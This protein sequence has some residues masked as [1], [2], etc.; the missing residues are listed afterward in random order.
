[1]KQLGNRTPAMEVESPSR[2]HRD[3]RV[4]RSRH[5]LP[6]LHGPDVIGSLSGGGAVGDQ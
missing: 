5:E 3:R 2:Y 4:L 6:I 1:M